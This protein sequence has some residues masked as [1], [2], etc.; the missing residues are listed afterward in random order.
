M[1]DDENVWHESSVLSEAL[2]KTVLPG[3][4]SILGGKQGL[5]ETDEDFGSRGL[6]LK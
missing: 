5:W 2:T 1:C 6:G 4:Q 3:L